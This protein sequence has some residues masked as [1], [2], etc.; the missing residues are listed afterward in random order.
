MRYREP[1]TPAG[2]A[3]PAWWASASAPLV[4]V[5]FGTVLGH[6]SF[7]GDVYRVLI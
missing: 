3:L 1:G 2:G 5:S 4:Y 6:M 7:A